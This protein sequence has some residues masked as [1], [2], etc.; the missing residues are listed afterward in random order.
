MKKTLILLSI[1]TSFVASAQSIEI[2]PNGGTNASAILDLKS[3]T[4]GF[5]LP[6][7]TNA[8]MRAIPSPAQGLLAF[9]TDCGTNGDYYFYKGTDWVA[10][11]STTVSVSTTMGSVSANADE[12]G[13]T[14]TNGVLNLAPANATKPGIITATDQT[15]GGVKTF[16]NGIVGNVTGNA[17]TA[18]KIASITN[19][20]IVQLTSTQTLTNKTLTSPTITGTG[21]IAGTFTG[22]L[23]GNA[24]TATTATTA[25]NISGGAAGSIPYQTATGSTSLL[26]AGSSGQ[27]LTSTGL[28]TLTWATASS[29]G[30]DLTTDQTIAGAKTFSAAPVLSSTTASKALF[31]DANKNIVSNEITGTG[32][33]VMSNS[34]ALVTPALGTPSA[35]VLTYAT[36]LP[37][38]SGAGVTG[39]LPVANG[40]TGTTNGSITG[41]GALT[42]AAGG[43]NQNISITPSGTGSVGIGT[44]SPNTTAALDVTSTTKGFLP[45]RLSSVQRNDITNPTEGL[46]IYNSTKHCL[47]V[48]RGAGAGGGWFNLC[49][50][51]FVGRPINKLLGG[52][53]YDYASNIQQTSDGGY[54]ISGYSYSSANGDVS[55]TNH[56]SYD[57]WIVK[58]DALGN[59]VWNKLLGGSGPETASNIQ[60]TTDGG[61]IISGYSSSSANGDVSG[62][63]HG[64]YDSW[65]VKLDALGN[66]IWNK[67]LGGSGPEIASNI[68]QTSDGGYIISGHSYSSANGDVSG[69]NHG[70]YDYWIV[71]LDALGN[72]VWNKLLGGSGNETAS[73]IQQT[74]DGGYIISGLSTS[75]ANGDVSGTNHGG[76][77]YWIVKLDALGNIVWNKLL[78]GSG[79][80]TASNIQQ[81]TDGGYIISG[82]SYSSSANGDVSGTNHGDYDSWIVKLDALG[83]II[84]NKLLGGSGPEIASNI[85][86][87]TDGGYIISGY[88]YSSA[89]GDV[90]GTNHGGA[91]YWIVKLDALG[92]IVWNK[93]LGGSYDDYA[94]HIQQTSDGDYIISGYSTSSANGDV[95]GTNH[96]SNDY[97]I[98]TLDALGNI[99]LF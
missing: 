93:L 71:K 38:T 83:N 50:N 25:T 32:N 56:G 76:S 67:L 47:E 95:S 35:A 15:F 39:T 10:L 4:K 60:Q 81:T 61:Y 46:V 74:T 97:W 78:G 43:S 52:S 53:S 92:N 8:Q 21:A 91:D 27:V 48:Y 37:L 24:S 73:N 82:Y 99:L 14:I 70:R 11:G 51:A 1:L 19:A 90:S 75:S 86:Q 49:D 85:Q 65:I 17:G 58:L 69:T 77:D 9:C 34:P 84:W 36:G 30:V 26:A 80:E 12:K 44:S 54:I 22:N 16:S 6:R 18:T 96:G 33:V 42:F 13:A 89:N 94:R 41:T 40:G 88:S 3:T 79:T 59:I 45:P 64:D 66:I 5:L 72:I 87:T 20:D 7:M 29:S 57:Y 23:T 62:T 63:N 68:Q 55:G 2:S 28:G 31:T 98:V